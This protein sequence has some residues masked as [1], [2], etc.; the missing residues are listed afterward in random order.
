M[1][2]SACSRVGCRLRG[3]WRAG[4]HL[5]AAGRSSAEGSVWG[6][7]DELAVGMGASGGDNGAAV[8][9]GRQRRWLLGLRGDYRAVTRLEKA[10]AAPRPKALRA[11][12]VNR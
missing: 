1:S 4:L 6:L 12:M 8:P 5:V 9:G 10:D 2:A 3:V 11:W 7:A